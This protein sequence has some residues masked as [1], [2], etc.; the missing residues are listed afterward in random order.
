MLRNGVLNTGRV[1]AKSSKPKKMRAST[2]SHF[3][4]DGRRPLNKH[5]MATNNVRGC[6]NFSGRVGSYFFWV[7]VGSGWLGLG[8]SLILLGLGWLV[9]NWEFLLHGWV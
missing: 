4:V 8:S 6:E 7:V 9:E 1:A 2:E 5:L 3:S